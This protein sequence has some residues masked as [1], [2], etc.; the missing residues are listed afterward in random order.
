MSPT[1]LGIITLNEK[2][3]MTFAIRLY[4]VYTTAIYY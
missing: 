3:R 2:R 4:F 1:N